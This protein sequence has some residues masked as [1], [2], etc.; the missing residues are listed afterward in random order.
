[1]SQISCC[2]SRT[3]FAT[4]FGCACSR[5]G[6]PSCR[7][8][9]FSCSPTTLWAPLAWTVVFAVI[10][11]LQ[12][13][14]LFIERQPIKL[15][16][17]E[18]EVR[19]LVFQDLPPR[20]VLH[21]LGLGTWVTAQPGTRMIE[22]GKV[23]DTVSLIVRG[24]VRITRDGQ[25]LGGLGAGQVVGSALILS[26]LQADVEAVVESPVRAV[27]WQVG[28]LERYLNANPDTRTAMQRH[29]ARDL[30]MKVERLASDSTGN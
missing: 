21:V 26:G 13:W 10:N 27:R 11:L 12:S 28:T 25:V 22:S 5:W 15:T 17:E 30:A 16:A 4:S 2:W 18:E 8:R 6:R 19:R 1:M 9:I 14:R 29:L 23:P 7:S 3:A 20:K 24:T